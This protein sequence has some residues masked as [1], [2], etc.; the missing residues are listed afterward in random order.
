MDIFLC[1]RITYKIDVVKNRQEG[2]QSSYMNQVLSIRGIEF[3]KL[4]RT[5]FQR[6]LSE[7]SSPF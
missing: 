1:W 5:Q 4:L 7:N 2:R 3:L 6:Y